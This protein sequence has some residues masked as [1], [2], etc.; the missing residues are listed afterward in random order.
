LRLGRRRVDPGAQVRTHPIRDRR[1]RHSHLDLASA[2]VDDQRSTDDSERSLAKPA[3]CVD[4]E[5]PGDWYGLDSP[6]PL[7]SERGREEEESAVGQ[8]YVSLLRDRVFP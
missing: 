6:A 2:G 7:A 8:N 4:R 1:R 3:G 5:D